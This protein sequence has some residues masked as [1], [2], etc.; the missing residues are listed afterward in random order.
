MNTAPGDADREEPGSLRGLD[1]ERRVP[2]VSR[3]VCTCAHSVESEQKRF[4]IGLVPG[5]LV[6]ADN[7]LEEMRDRNARE[8]ELD[9]LTSLRGDDA[10]PAAFV[11]QPN[12]PVVHPRA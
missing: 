1:V 3:L 5:R 2:D 7:R 9:G 12:E 8:R 6:A 11:L 10:Q 4:R